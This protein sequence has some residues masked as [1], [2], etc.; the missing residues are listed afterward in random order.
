MLELPEIGKRD[1]VPRIRDLLA[2][3]D[4]KVKTNTNA[5]SHGRGAATYALARQGKKKKRKK[6]W[7][8]NY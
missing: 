7:R 3:S 1:E 8:E 4:D 2:F 5:E 6:H